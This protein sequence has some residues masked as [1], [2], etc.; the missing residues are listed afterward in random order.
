MVTTRR[1]FLGNTLGVAAVVAGDPVTTFKDYLFGDD[2]KGFLPIENEEDFDRVF[3]AFDEVDYLLRNDGAIDE[4]PEINGDGA[5]YVLGKFGTQLGVAY[6]D[7]FESPDHFLD[8]G[9]LA[10]SIA[11]YRSFQDS[12][13]RNWSGGDV[14]EVVPTSFYNQGIDGVAGDLDTVDLSRPSARVLDAMVNQAR[15]LGGEYTFVR[16]PMK[17]AIRT[18]FANPTSAAIIDGDSIVLFYD[19]NHDGASYDAISF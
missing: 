11:S 15:E 12:I 1:G 10:Q 4:L 18:H 7:V 13:F 5:M 19:R 14:I 6:V 3:G 8:E 16:V 9:H 17:D 2:R